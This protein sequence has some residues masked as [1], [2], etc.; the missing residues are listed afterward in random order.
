M[1]NADDFIKIIDAAANIMYK[2]RKY[3][4]IVGG[5]IT[6]GFAELKIPQ[7]V[8]I[9]GDIHGDLNSLFD[10][11]KDV[12]Y[13][14]FLADA[15]NKMIFMGD[16]VD[17][18]SQSIGVLYTICYLKQ[19]YPDSV[20]LMRGNHEA[21]IEFPFSSHD[22]PFEIVERYGERGK[23]QIYI[24]RILPF[25]RLLILSTLIQSQVLIVHGGVPTQCARLMANFKNS[26]AT[27]EQNIHE[28]WMEEI[29]WN[30]PRQHIE[31]HNEW[32]PSRRGIGRHFGIN[33]SK[34]WL[35]LTGTK[36]II[37]GHEPCRGFKIDHD[38]LVVTLFSCKEA[39]PSFEAAYLSVTTQQWQSIFNGTDLKPYISKLT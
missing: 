9:I 25:F 24:N 37:R 28:G 31:N 11:L 38:G 32:E 20:I 8:V 39:Y 27:A 12:E 19:K 26:I 15:K 13:E 30:D 18:G 1:A 7:N 4:N 17:R 3:S 34:R 33:I 35:R 29:L 14:K 23:Q 21:P 16:Y 36:M 2:E 22:L 6:C 10:I 5:S